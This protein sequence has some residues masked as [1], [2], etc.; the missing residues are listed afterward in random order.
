MLARGVDLSRQ[1]VSLGLISPADAHRA[2]PPPDAGDDELT[3]EALLRRLVHQ[4]RL[5]SFQADEI[6]AGRA[7]ALVLGDYV[8]EDRLGLGGMGEVFRARHRKMNRIVAVKVLSAAAARSTETLGRFQREVQ[9]TGR[10]RHPNIVAALDASEHQGTHFLVMEYVDGIDLSRWLKQ[11]GAMSIDQALDVILQAARGLEHAHGEGIVHRDIKP[12]N[13]LLDRQGVV[14]ILDMGAA[15]IETL[16]GALDADDEDDALTHTGS[17]LGTIDYM[18]PEQASNLRLADGRADVYSLGCTL[19]RL[20]TGQKLYR[21]GSLFERITAHRDAPIP[22]LRAVRPDVPEALDSLFRRMVAKRPEERYASM[23][24]LMHDLESLRALLDAGQPIWPSEPT[25]AASAVAAESSSS[26]WSQTPVGSL[27]LAGASPTK[28]WS[29]EAAPAAESARPTQ[30]PA[31]ESSRLPNSTPA[32]SNPSWAVPAMA[33]VGGG[34]V[35]LIALA[36]PSSGP[37][38][39][40]PKRSAASTILKDEAVAKESPLSERS[41]ERMRREIDASTEAWK[42][43]QQRDQQ[44][45]AQQLEQARREGDT[46]LTAPLSL[47]KLELELE[48]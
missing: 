15:R 12:G 35:L 31:P 30:T 24:D 5:T 37:K 25:P 26:Q 34:L 36:A 22:S 14:K 9:V 32:D 20:L 23:S 39:K 33:A 19:Y 10:L 16:W 47:P 44:K 21:A 13:L 40:S 48:R 17:M 29:S 27:A 7:A 6:R 8:L 38:A 28:A 42:Q 1:L 11:H 18:A 43:A 46:F 2:A 4:R 45:T 41:L 3:G